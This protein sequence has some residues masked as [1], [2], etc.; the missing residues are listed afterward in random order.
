MVC[1]DSGDVIEFFDP[2]IEK[3]QKEIVKRHGY[4]L[5]DHNLVLYVRKKD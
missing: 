1:V 3:L 2:E 5:V 4:E